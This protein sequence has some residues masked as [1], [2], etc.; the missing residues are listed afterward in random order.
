MGELCLTLISEMELE[1]VSFV[2]NPAN[3][4][5]RIMTIEHD[6]KTIDILTLREVEKIP[7]EK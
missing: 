4:H 7:T 3:K 1:E 6:E 5:C 2:D